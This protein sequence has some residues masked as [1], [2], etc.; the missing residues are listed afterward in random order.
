MKFEA[1]I[2]GIFYLCVYIHTYMYILGGTK[3]S[4]IFSNSRLNDQR[5]YRLYVLSTP[6]SHIWHEICTYSKKLFHTLHNSIKVQIVGHWVYRLKR[7][8]H[9]IWI[10]KIFFVSQRRK[11]FLLKIHLDKTT[12]TRKNWENKVLKVSPT[13]YCYILYNIWHRMTLSTIFLNYF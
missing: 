4:N 5:L 3:S 10:Y 2:V 6:R 8:V 1:V 11:H 13:E 9:Q 12:L 7:I